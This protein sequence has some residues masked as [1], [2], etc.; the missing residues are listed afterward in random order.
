MSD[1][2]GERLDRRSG[3]RSDRPWK[4]NSANDEADRQ[5][6][7][8]F[9]AARGALFLEAG[10]EEGVGDTGEELVHGDIPVVSSLRW[11]E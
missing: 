11:D 8:A 3:N 1:L 6:A 10:G 7:P 2:G 9:V 4:A 5:V